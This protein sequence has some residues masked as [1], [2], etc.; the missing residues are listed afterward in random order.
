MMFSVLPSTLQ[1]YTSGWNQW[2]TYVTGFKLDRF[3]RY[4]PIHWPSTSPYP[5]AESA[6]SAFITYAYFQLNLVPSTIVCYVSGIKFYITNE[7][8]TTVAFQSKYVSATK[9]AITLHYRGQ[10]PISER[11][12]FPFT[13]DMIQYLVNNIIPSNTPKNRAI[14]TAIQLAF[15]CLMR[16]SEYIDTS[17]NHHLLTDDVF[18]IVE[19]AGIESSVNCTLIS[20]VSLSNITAVSITVRNA[21]NDP[22]GISNTL[23]FYKTVPIKGAFDLC[24]IMYD[25]SAYA[26]PI[27]SVPFLWYKGSRIINSED[28]NSSIQLVATRNGF[29]ACHFSSKSLRVGG[30]STLAAAA[31]PSY[32]IQKI[33]RWKS[34]TFLQYIKLSFEACT[35]VTNALSNPSLLTMSHLRKQYNPEPKTTVISKPT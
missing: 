27:I 4:P 8:F 33:G 3:L 10:H 13:L 20:T 17:S 25:W 23:C 32:I 24:T 22:L 35:Y 34:L 9:S 26:V 19:I 7:G 28:I 12:T 2:L 21:K 31:T 14:G 15:S 16:I 30:A 6:L 11:D 5:F 18:F 29:N 1:T